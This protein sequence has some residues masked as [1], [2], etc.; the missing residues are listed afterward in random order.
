MP[1][2]PDTGIQ[3][4]DG[5]GG[6]QSDVY[7]GTY[8][9]KEAAE[10]GLAELTKTLSRY[11]SERDHA[12]AE[13][14]KLKADVLSKLADA[15]AQNA[16]PAEP[17]EDPQAQVDA[18]VKKM[19]KAMED[20]DYEAAA[21]MQ[22]EIQSGW[23]TQSEQQL[24]ST[25]EQELQERADKLGLTVKELKAVIDARDPDMLAYGEA[26]KELAES[27]GV[28]FDGNRDM[29]IKIAKKNA[30]TDAPPRHE[31][32][33]G[34]VANGVVGS[35]GGGVQLTAAE[36]AAIGWDKLSPAEQKAMEKKWKA[37]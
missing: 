10:K 25:F 9:T 7:L 13:A 21:R 30:T 29:F 4:G 12:K 36:K 11:Q 26:A 3:D 27:V 34:S 35:D 1:D 14:E 28:D 18:A 24:K 16:K 5:T 32:P 31:L 22:L 15:T 20:G 2:T 23:L 33:G 19:A 6:D 8:K 17:K 37:K